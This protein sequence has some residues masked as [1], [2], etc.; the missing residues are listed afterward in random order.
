M[1]FS[2]ETIYSQNQD[3]DKM[4]SL[5]SGRL[6]FASTA[7]SNWYNGGFQTVMLGYGQ[8]NALDYMEQSIGLHIFAHNGFVDIIQM[9]GLIG[10]FLYILFIIYLFKMIHK[11]K[12]SKYYQLSIILYISYIFFMILQG[13]HF[14]LPEVILSAVLAVLYIDGE[15]I[16]R[17]NRSE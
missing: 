4:R 13:G 7:L 15:Q 14:F 16:E 1:R 9:N 11:N 2:D 6:Y 10:I 3:T 5:G 8:G 12:N 17:K